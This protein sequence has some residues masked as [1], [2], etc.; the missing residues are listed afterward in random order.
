M[1]AWW[2]ITEDARVAA[3]P[4]LFGTVM[5]CGV[6]SSLAQAR[7]LGE[8]NGALTRVRQ[9][10]CSPYAINAEK[11]SSNKSGG[12]GEAAVL[13]S[14]TR[15]P[16]RTI[17]ER[18]VAQASRDRDNAAVNHLRARAAGS[19]RSPSPAAFAPSRPR[20]SSFPHTPSAA[21][22]APG[23]CRRSRSPCPAAA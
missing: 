15:L 1:P 19:R 22:R 23:S 7:K 8:L 5:C 14:A 16:H 3:C 11:V 2:F 10:L 20:S 18:L 13:A 21:E 6:F 17:L 12:R 4:S 9:M